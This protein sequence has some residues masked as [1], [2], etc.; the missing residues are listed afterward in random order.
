MFMKR[1]TTKE[2]LLSF[3]KG[4]KP[5]PPGILLCLYRNTAGEVIVASVSL[6]TYNKNIVILE[7]ETKEDIEFFETFDSKPLIELELSKLTSK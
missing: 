4:E 1:K 5:K 2:E 7:C 3:A 6:L